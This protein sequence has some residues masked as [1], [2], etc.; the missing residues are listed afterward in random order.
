MKRDLLL[1]KENKINIA[2]RI[3]VGEKKYEDLWIQCKTRYES[4]PLVQRML[5]GKKKCEMLT[6][7]MNVLE[8]EAQKLDKAIKAKKSVLAEKDKKR[9]IQLAEFI[10]H[11][12]PVTIKAIKEKTAIINDMTKELE[13]SPMSKEVDST[14]TSPRIEK[15]HNEQGSAESANDNWFISNHLMVC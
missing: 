11:E 10:V 6:K 7:D 15:K 1:N 14:K 2:E 4:I 8:T 3:K 12:R 5:E 13:A 9:V